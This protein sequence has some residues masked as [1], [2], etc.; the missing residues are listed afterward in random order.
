MFEM[1]YSIYVRYGWRGV[2][3]VVY[4]MIKHYLLHIHI[5][6]GGRNKISND[7]PSKKMQG[8]PRDRLIQSL[9]KNG[10]IYPLGDPASS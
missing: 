7:L 5:Y 2:E 3:R 6:C 9:V 1:L 8:H 10:L 4:Y